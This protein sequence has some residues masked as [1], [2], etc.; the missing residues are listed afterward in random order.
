MPEDTPSDPQ[1]EPD[2]TSSETGRDD[3][4]MIAARAKVWFF[5]DDKTPVDFVLYALEQYFGYDE[6]KARAIVERIR[7]QGKAVAA[8]LPAIP[9]EL[10]RRKVEQAAADAGYPFRVE[11]EGGPQIV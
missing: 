4:T 6:P 8:E 9:A 3:S 10:A 1:F 7:K 11:I 5:D 2:E